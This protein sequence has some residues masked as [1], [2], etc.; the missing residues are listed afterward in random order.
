MADIDKEE[1][2]NQLYKDQEDLLSQMIT[3]MLTTKKI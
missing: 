2:D 1:A 3:E